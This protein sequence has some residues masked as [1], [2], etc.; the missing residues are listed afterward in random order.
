[1][2]FIQAYL[3]IVAILGAILL[4]AI[5]VDSA[6]GDETPADVKKKKEPKQ[7]PPPPLPPPPNRGPRP[8]SQREAGSKP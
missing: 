6:H 1:M 3:L 2:K 8:G 7:P 5:L 4:T